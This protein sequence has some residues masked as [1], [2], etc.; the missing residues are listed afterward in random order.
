[1]FFISEFLKNILEFIYR[2]VGNYGWSVVLFT[3]LIRMV[4]LPLDIKSK[5][6]MAR[7][8]ALQP[9]M[10]LLQDK[11]A[12]DK[13]KLNVKLNEL[14]RKEKVSPFSGCLPM[15]LSMPILF[16]M[17]DAMR[18]LANEHTVQMLLNAM[19]DNAIDPNSLQ[20]W[21][22]IKNVFQPDSFMST[23]VPTVG[24]ALQGITQINGS[25]ILT[26]ENLEA[27]RTF[28][29]TDAY[30]A[31]AAQFGATT[32]VYSAPLLFW[33]IN[34]PGQINGW[35]ILPVL[36]AV[37]QFV[38]SKLM[39]PS[40]NQTE[41]QQS[42]NKMMTWFFPIFSLFICSSYTAAFAIYWVA[43]NIIQIVQQYFVNMIVNKKDVT[44][45]EVINP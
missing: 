5:K 10:K 43:V 27:V 9:K 18:V 17:F 30:A 22:W 14:Y 3:F 42:T 19:R 28:L 40:G 32:T 15:L 2:Y 8:Q 44:T 36:A 23:I 11:Y 4:L 35:F 21:L 6:S 12:N 39:T 41:Q 45:E 31:I 20:S 29:S 7:V 24:N 16:C 38:S 33:T 25:E 1:M 26:P 13:E 34:I 37:S